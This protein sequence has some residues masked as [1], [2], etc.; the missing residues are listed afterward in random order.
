M[1]IS[2]RSLENG[3]VAV[4]THF[5]CRF[6]TSSGG[7]RHGIHEEAALT[8]VQPLSAPDDGRNET[9]HMKM[10]GGDRRALLRF[11]VV[12]DLEGSLNLVESP[13]VVDISPIGALVL[14]QQSFPIESLQTI[15]L[16]V[17][18]QA[19]PIAG[20]VRHVHR[21][22]GED[23]FARY[24]VGFELLSVPPAL[25]EVLKSLSAENVAR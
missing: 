14:S 25:A 23:G 13:E 19:A 7:I 6:C 8:L 2:S 11:E 5:G 9:V 24:L 15:Q 17:K 1:W 20:K 18:G 10:V 4:K 12:G 3:R 22:I 16:S 21:V